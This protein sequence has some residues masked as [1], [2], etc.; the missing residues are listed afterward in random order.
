MPRTTHIIH[1]QI[2][3]NLP[4]ASHGEGPYVIDTQGKRYLDACGGAAVSCLG[5]SHPRVTQA[6]KDQLDKIA[7]A[8]SGFFTSEPAEALADFL[9]QRAPQ[10]IEH[11]YFVSGGSEALESAMKLA[12]QYFLERGEPQR[13]TFIARRQSYHGNTLGALAAG[14]NLAR[15]NDFQPLLMDVEHISPCYAYRDQ[16]AD[17]S[18]EDYGLRV[19]NELDERLQ[20]VG[21]EN[22]I[23]FIAEPIGGATAGV[24]M[25]VPGYWKRIREICDQR[26]ILLILD[27]V[28]CGMGRTGSL[29]ACEQEALRPDIVT[30]AKALGAG[31][32]AIGAMLCSHV[33][34][35]TV[36]TGSGTFKHGH[37]YL[38]HSAACA[39]ALAVQ[40]SVEDENLLENVRN[41][42]TLLQ[43]TLQERLADHSAIG[44]IR[45]RGLFWGVELVAD[46][47]NKRPFDPDL[48][49]DQLIKHHAMDLGLMCYP[50]SG[51]IDGV[52]GNHILLA[53]AFII[54]P[55]QVHE[56]VEK[57]AQA[58]D[59]AAKEI[60]AE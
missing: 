12:R 46:K 28:M 26:G 10:G 39:A 4:M 25:P 47:A 56:I 1:R 19:A 59:A 2:R 48:R 27:E 3:S 44:D 43:Q 60:G 35:E 14:G 6:I 7:F 9:V 29:F 31:Y 49:V 41:M 34:F 57:L 52:H 13:Q 37:T 36:R 24:L 15:R 51:T 42:G 53:P 58:I 23:A 50:G 16:G 32:Q 33:I 45:G 22:V 55:A 11:A 17:E 30:V 8:H 20:Q 40:H 38:A 54:Q 5:Y 18:V 21:A